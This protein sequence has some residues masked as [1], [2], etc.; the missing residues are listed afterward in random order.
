MENFDF[1]TLCDDVVTASKKAFSEI[2]ARQPDDELCAFALY[3]D[4]GAMTIC[5][6][7]CT[8]S[9]LAAKAQEEPDELPF[10]KYSPSEWP[11]EGEGASEAFKSICT[12]VREQVFSIEDDEEA[13]DAFKR[14]LIET[15]I[16]A[17]LRLRHEFFEP[18]DKNLLLLVTISDDDEPAAELQSRVERLNDST[19]SA[20]FAAWAETWA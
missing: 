9:F 4:S 3:S 16:K 14:Q 18:R 10:Y 1:S 5:P 6:A 19:Q 12:T 13:F 17:Q 15:C 7:M 8:A 2:A 20:E 11:W